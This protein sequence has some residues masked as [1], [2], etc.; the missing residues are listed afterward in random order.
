M[1]SSI[2]MQHHSSYKNNATLTRQFAFGIH[3]AIANIA[4]EW[5]EIWEV[6]VSSILDLSKRSPVVSS[7]HKAQRERNYLNL[8]DHHAAGKA[9]E[10]FRFESN[11][12]VRQAFYFAAISKE[13]PST[14]DNDKESELPCELQRIED[15]VAALQ[16]NPKISDSLRTMLLMARRIQVVTRLEQ[17][18]WGT[19][20]ER[21]KTLDD[22]I[23]PKSGKTPLDEIAEMHRAFFNL[24]V[25]IEGMDIIHTEA[26]AV[27]HRPIL[28]LNADTPRR[29]GAHHGFHQF[30]HTGPEKL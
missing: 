22:Y 21:L 16:V 14:L 5:Q 26:T 23:L 29:R 25:K 6:T 13:I 15:P 20:P 27:M 8:R 28:M 9:L 11:L 17:S 2:S 30:K 18:L 4:T 10:N 12:S 3:A 1:K 19:L 24:R 7:P